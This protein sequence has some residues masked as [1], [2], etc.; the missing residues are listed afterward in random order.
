MLERSGLELRLHD[1]LATGLCYGL[2]KFS[3]L[4]TLSCEMKG[5]T[6]ML[7]GHRVLNEANIYHWHLPE[8][9]GQ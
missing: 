2:V 4:S 8:G 1:S 5:I 6:P 7:Q 9:T 3:G